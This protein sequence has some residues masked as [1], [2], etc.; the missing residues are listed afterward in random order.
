MMIKITNK[1]CLPSPLNM[2]WGQGRGLHVLLSCHDHDGGKGMI[3]ILRRDSQK[4]EEREAARW[5]GRRESHLCTRKNHIE[6]YVFL[7]TIITRENRENRENRP[8]NSNSKVIR[9]LLEMPEKLSGA[10]LKIS[11]YVATF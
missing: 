1:L 4:R 9:I 6:F 11:F 3:K 2:K 10:K 7:I 8:S 5:G